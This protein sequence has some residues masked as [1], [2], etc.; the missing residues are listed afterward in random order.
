MKYKLPLS[1]L[2][3]FFISCE[4]GDVEI[5]DSRPIF[6]SSFQGNWVLVNYWADWCPP[7]IKEIPE[8]A[9]FANKYPEVKVF[10]FNFDR[11][12]AED[13]RPQIKKFGISYPSIMTH[14]RTL[15]GIKTPKTLPATYFI[16]PN[17]EIVFS[18]LKTQDEE[19]LSLTYETL[20][21]E[22]K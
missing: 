7:C 9:A 2:C 11:L 12:E 20:K 17:G 3:L 4:Q 10:A 5:F 6:S 21:M 22:V 15:W 14:P 16:S 13:L 8:I 18:S 19:S 1:L